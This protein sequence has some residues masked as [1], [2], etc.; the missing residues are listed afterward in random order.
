MDGP[1]Q[2]LVDVPRGSIVAEDLG[3]EVIEGAPARHCRTF[4]DGP[5]AL[6]AFLPLRWLLDDGLARGAT[7]VG[8]WR[9]E[10][11][12]W[13]FGDGELGRA[14]VEVS[15]SR[16]DT[17]LAG[18]RRPGH[19]RGR[20][21]GRRSGPPG[22]HLGAQRRHRGCA[23][24]RRAM[25]TFDERGGSK[26]DRAARYLRIAQVLHA[27]GEEG[28]SAAALARQVG[29][30]KRTVYRDLA[31]MDLDGGLAIWNDGGRFGLE[32][33]A[34]LPPL[35]LTLPEAMAFLLAARLLTKATDELDPEIIGAFV[36]LAQ[37]LPPVL[38]EQLHETA[39][40]FADTPRDEAFTRVVRGLT[41]ALAE[42]RIV[43]ME[44]GAGV[45][46]RSKGVRRV[47][48]HPYAIEPSA[49]TRAL[50]VIGHD[51][52]RAARRTFKVE[53]IR[54]VSVTPERFPPRE[55]HVAAE[56][57]SAWD[58]VADE[59]LVRRRRP[60]RSGGRASGSPRRAGIPARSLETGADGSLVWRARVSGVLEVRSWILGWGGDAEV[61]EPPDAPR[62][63]R[64]PARRRRAALRSL[65]RRR[66]SARAPASLQR[67]DRRDEVL[68]AGLGVGEE[69][70]RL[71]VRV[72]RVVD[73]R[74]A[75]AHG[76]LDDDDAL[77]LVDVEDG[78]AVDGRR[79]VGAGHRVGDVVG[80]DDEGH[81]A[82]R[83]LGVDLLHLLELRV[84]HVGLRQQHV[85][86]AGH[87]PGHRMD[88]V[89]DLDAALLE[90]VAE[91]AHRR[92][93]PG[94]RR[95]RSRAR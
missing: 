65:D 18:L 79:R 86:V 51:E 10:M 74:V 66:R 60:L 94:P 77:G 89:A 59:P 23:T 85:H 44:Y 61:L 13:V 41:V 76:A 40:A 33:D 70:A 32:A 38:A 29:V 42:R 87:A 91:L 37:V 20:A 36:K 72:E 83:E 75:A 45:Y 78:H 47:R 5:T 11:D 80:A 15:G 52:E 69:H 7:D 27:H 64:R 34:F 55:P 2:A 50:Y 8:R 88:G 26:W 39:S 57:R 24:V 25:S 90:D 16:A 1:P 68:E 43:E 14:R 95:G 31:A 62:L 54:S 19:P 35:A 81:V 21:R 58:V 28:I 92:A 73:A 82:A 67:L 56:M 49:A 22:E 48:I 3:I 93:A 46:D 17:D 30:S 9:G 71:G 12:W 84:G 53:R 6:D 4:M 63:G